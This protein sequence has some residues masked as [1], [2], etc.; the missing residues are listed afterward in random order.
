MAIHSLLIFINEN[1]EIILGSCG[2]NL[3]LNGECFVILFMEYLDNMRGQTVKCLSLPTFQ[4][5]TK[6]PTI[7]WEVQL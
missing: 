1:A 7:P 4:L 5:E 6:N 3:F 2:E